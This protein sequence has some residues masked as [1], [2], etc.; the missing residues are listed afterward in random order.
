MVILGGDT[1][2]IYVRTAFR[3]LKGMRL[4]ELINNEEIKLRKPEGVIIASGEGGRYPDALCAAGLS[5][6]LATL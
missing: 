6:A 4:A 3:V 1:I 5:G 2:S